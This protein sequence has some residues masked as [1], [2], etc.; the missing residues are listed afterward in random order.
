MKVD[1]FV[2]ES[3]KVMQRETHPY[4]DVKK[5]K[6]RSTM[7]FIHEVWFKS[8]MN[9][10]HKNTTISEKM[11][12]RSNTSNRKPCITHIF[13]DSMQAIIK[14]FNSAFGKGCTFYFKEHSVIYFFE[15]KNTTTLKCYKRV[16]KITAQM[17]THCSPL[18]IHADPL[19]NHWSF[20]DKIK[21]LMGR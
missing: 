21:T 20:I 14:N 11:V 15:K 19:Q 18:K 8:W 13:S 10:R 12:A 6:R 5:Y 3:N 16:Y 9:K 2:M 7:I 4:S 1:H 17:L